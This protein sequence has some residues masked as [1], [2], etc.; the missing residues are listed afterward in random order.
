MARF[1]RRAAGLLRAAGALGAVPLALGGGVYADPPAAQPAGGGVHLVGYVQVTPEQAKQEARKVA[2]ALHADAVSSQLPLEVCLDGEALELRG[3]VPGEAHRQ[4][5]LDVARQ[6]CYLPVHDG[7][8]VAQ[9]DERPAPG[10]TAEVL[11]EAVRESLVENLH[12]G[13]GSPP[14]ADG[15]GKQSGMSEKLH[16]AVGEVLAANAGVARPAA[17]DPVKAPIMAKAKPAAR[18]EQAKPPG[19]ADR[20]RQAVRESFQHGLARVGLVRET[21]AAPPQAPVAAEKAPPEKVPL[22]V[23]PPEK[24]PPQ[25]APPEKAPPVEREAVAQNV[26]AGAA[27]GAGSVPVFAV[28]L[29]QEVQETVVQKGAPEGEGPRLAPQGEVVYVQRSAAV[30]QLDHGWTI[31]GVPAAAPTPTAPAAPAAPAAPVGRTV[32]KEV[33]GGMAGVRLMG[34]PAAGQVVAQ[35]PAEPVEAPQPVGPRYVQGP[36]AAVPLPPSPTLTM[37]SGLPA[38]PLDQTLVRQTP[39]PTTVWPVAPIAANAMPTAPFPA[40][41]AQRPASYLA[42]NLPP[43]AGP[44]TCAVCVRGQDVEQPPPHT[45]SFWERLTGYHRPAPQP[46]VRHVTCGSGPWPQGEPPIAVAP[47]YTSY[48]I[49]PGYAPLPAAPTGSVVAVIP[50]GSPGPGFPV[51]PV[52]TPVAA[53]PAQAVATPAPEQGPELGDPPAPAAPP[54]LTPTAASVPQERVTPAWPPAHRV[55]PADAVP[56]TPAPA[57]AAFRPKPLVISPTPVG[58]QQPAAAPSQVR[59][60]VTH[61]AGEAKPVTPVSGQAVRTDVQPT[62]LLQSIRQAC[63]KLAQE[64]RLDIGPDHAPVVRVVATKAVEQDLLKALLAVPEVGVASIRVEVNITQ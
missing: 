58:P 23:A 33:G 54:R 60:T 47:Q 22:A 52:R 45:P 39:T 49:P 51:G 62:Y 26:A 56:Y 34:Y 46:Q 18:E 12:L 28:K 64:V 5:V 41:Y 20:L 19:L 27:G 31:P 48:R 16:E 32:V 4:R 24:A 57:G 25:K 9:Q 14:P 35:R 40:G 42:L 11:H 8:R 50:P 6:S 44:A 53:P 61:Q 36:G 59:L 2:T 37:P 1:F 63:G 10:A 30:S 7:M 17:E 55:Q 13:G 21:P 43:S 15:P 29:Q 3:V 38:R